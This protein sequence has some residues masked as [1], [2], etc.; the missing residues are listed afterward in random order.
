VTAAKLWQ[1]PEARCCPGYHG[2]VVTPERVIMTSGAGNVVALE[3]GAVEFKPRDWRQSLGRLSNILAGQ[4]LLWLP[5]GSGNRLGSDWGSRRADGKVMI[6]GFA[7]DLSDPNGPKRLPGTRLLGGLN[8]PRVPEMEKYAPEMYA[9]PEYWGNWSCYGKP[10]HFVHT[11]TAWMP[12]GNRL[13]LR[14]VGHLYCLGD[15]SV[16]YNWNLKSRPANIAVK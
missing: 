10:P 9:L 16:P 8:W 12:M 11:D 15:P 14:T 5:E 1:T 6:E 7:A 2:Q 3:T 4:T 13:F